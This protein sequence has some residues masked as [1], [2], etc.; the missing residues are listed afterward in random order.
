MTAVSF[1]GVTT[2]LLAASGGSLVS[3]LQVNDGKTVR[4]FTGLGGF[5]QA[6]GTGRGHLAA[7]T[8]AGQLAGW[9]I[10]EPAAAWTCEP[11]ASGE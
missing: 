3:L 11:V 5:I 7:G 4:R 6:L 8:A 2:E 9:Q 10:A 1:A